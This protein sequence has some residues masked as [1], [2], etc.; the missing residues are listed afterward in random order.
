MS[1]HKTAFYEFDKSRAPGELAD[2]LS[3]MLQ[4]K[5]GHYLNFRED[6]DG[7][8]GRIIVAED[9]A[10]GAS[11]EQR[12]VITEMICYG[13]CAHTTEFHA[14]GSGEL[15]CEETSSRFS[16]QVAAPFGGEYQASNII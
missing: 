1:S 6:L 10:S 5:D 14:D 9:D 7:A 11:N 15:A 3:S 13:A 16:S 8:Y 4:Y 12:P 2:L